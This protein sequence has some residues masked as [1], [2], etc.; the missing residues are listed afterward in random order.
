MGTH[1][2]LAACGVREATFKDGSIKTELFFGISQA[3]ECSDTQMISGSTRNVGAWAER[4]GAG[5]GYKSSRYACGPPNC[6]IVIWLPPNSS[7]ENVEKLAA[8]LEDI[9]LIN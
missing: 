1:F 7:A 5:L 2:L 6:Q 4:R 8:K 3:L 9:C